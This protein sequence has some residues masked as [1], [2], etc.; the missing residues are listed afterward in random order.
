MPLPREIETV[1]ISSGGTT[2][3]AIPCLDGSLTAIVCPSALTSTALSFT[4]ATTSGGTY[5]T[6]KAMDGASTYSVT[7]G[8]S[9]VVPLDPRV[10]ASLPYVKLVFGTAEGADRS[11][12]I[13]RRPI[14]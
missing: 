3:A 2:S 5:K 9:F 8:A 4:A 11:I 10:F 1:T 14:S 12:E 13:I 7:V 6:V